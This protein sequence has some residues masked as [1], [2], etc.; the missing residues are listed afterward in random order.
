MSEK[1]IVDGS[2]I[3]PNVRKFGPFNPP[4]PALTNVVGE[5]PVVALYLI[6]VFVLNLS[7]RTSPTLP[8]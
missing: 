8:R 1:A 6:T 7:L 2:G 3:V 4:L 5:P